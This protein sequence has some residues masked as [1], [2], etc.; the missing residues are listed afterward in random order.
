MSGGAHTASALG[1][2]DLRAHAQV[3]SLGRAKQV[4]NGTLV[5]PLRT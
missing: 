2:G 1:S 5:G 3:T 4:W